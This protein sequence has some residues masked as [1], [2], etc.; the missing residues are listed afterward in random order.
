MKQLGHTFRYEY[1]ERYQFHPDARVKHWAKSA[2]VSGGSVF[3][4]HES[5]LNDL[6]LHHQ[7]QGNQQAAWILISF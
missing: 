7:E 2:S 3:I 6:C 5:S 1:E 4:P